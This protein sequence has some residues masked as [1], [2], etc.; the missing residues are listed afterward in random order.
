MGA[1]QEVAAEW[2]NASPGGKALMITAVIAVAGLGLY[3]AHLK[4]SAASSNSGTTG[5]SLVPFDMGTD[6]GSI[7]SPVDTSGTTG[8]T[9]SGATGSTPTSGGT[10]ATPKPV[11]K[12]S[13]PP[14]PVPK[15]SPKPVAKPKPVTYV[16][17][18]KWVQ[19][20]N[21]PNELSSLSAIAKKY[22]GNANKWTV[23]YDANKNQIKNPNLIYA[24]QRLLLPGI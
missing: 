3:T 11:P 9:T 16:T 6:T 23:I 8:S 21:N 2:S 19:G 15:P 1:L 5:G 22:Y 17:V 24:G 18:Q 10:T 12:P 4:T 13:P 14:K 20:F 7:T